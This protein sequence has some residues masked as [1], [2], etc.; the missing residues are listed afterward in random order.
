VLSDPQ[1]FEI[2]SARKMAHVIA[3]QKLQL[4]TF[5]T[6]VERAHCGNIH[7]VP[8]LVHGQVLTANA[9]LC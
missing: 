7:P 8:E 2:L 4:C 3:G 1:Q 5:H 6:D 9:V